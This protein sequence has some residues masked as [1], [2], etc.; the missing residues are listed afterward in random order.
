MTVPLDVRNDIRSMDA[1]GVPRAEIARRLRLSRNTVAKYADMEDLSP[2]P[3]APA[4]RP[5]PAIDPHAAWIDGVLEADLGA[6]RKQ[7]HTAKRIYDRLVEERRYEGSYS[8]VQRHVREWRL[9][10]C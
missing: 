3:P 4:D 10:R 5:H 8:A 7:R 1:E 6:P 9:A 2:E